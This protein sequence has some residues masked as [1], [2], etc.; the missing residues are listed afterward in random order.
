VIAVPLVIE[1]R[2]FTRSVDRLV[3]MLLLLTRR[4]S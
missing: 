3:E 1:Q 4:S 2:A